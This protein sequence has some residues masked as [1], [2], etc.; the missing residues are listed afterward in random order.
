[1]SPGPYARWPR[2]YPFWFIEGEPSNLDVEKTLANAQTPE[3]TDAITSNLFPVQFSGAP[4][5]YN[6]SL[7][8][9]VDF[10][11]RRATEIANGGGG[12]QRLLLPNWN[13]DADRGYG[14]LCWE[15]TK[16]S[17]G[18]DTQLEP[19]PLPLPNGVLIKQLPQS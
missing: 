4:V 11:V 15:I 16:D 13:L 2:N 10:Y 19:P 5:A 18:N 17:N 14:S 6:G 8:S 12:D 3:Q 1:M 9:A 7:G